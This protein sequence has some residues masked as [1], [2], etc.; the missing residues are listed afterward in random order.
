MTLT[1]YL[2]LDINL[3]I[4]NVYEDVCEITF[5]WHSH[6]FETDVKLYMPSFPVLYFM[7]SL[8]YVCTTAEIAIYK[9]HI[10][11][12]NKIRKLNPPK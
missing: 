3:D 5:T 8:A 12:A 7:G 11:I 6:E 4:Y 2:H 9:R 1:H 10:H